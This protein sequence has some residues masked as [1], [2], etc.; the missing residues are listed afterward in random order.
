MRITHLDISMSL[1]TAVVTTAPTD[2]AGSQ[3]NRPG[4]RAAA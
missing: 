3:T 2:Q 1:D 4:C